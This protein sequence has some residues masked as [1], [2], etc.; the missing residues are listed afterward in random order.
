MR[1]FLAFAIHRQN[2]SENHDIFGLFT[3]EDM[4][5]KWWRP[6]VDSDSLSRLRAYPKPALL[7]TA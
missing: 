6:F 1:R 5:L 7:I 4:F 2:E 3:I